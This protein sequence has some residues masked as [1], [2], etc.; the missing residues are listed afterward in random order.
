MSHPIANN[1]S[2]RG[3]LIRAASGRSFVDHRNAYRSSINIESS[4]SGNIVGEMVTSYGEWRAS[5]EEKL[6]HQ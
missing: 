4:M 1:N 2:P 3:C 5:Y 6:S